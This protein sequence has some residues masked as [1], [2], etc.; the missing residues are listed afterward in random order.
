MTHLFL[1]ELVP[2]NGIFDS[3]ESFKSF[4]KTITVKETR[5]EMYF[6]YSLRFMAS[7]L[8]RLSENLAQCECKIYCNCLRNNF[9]HTF[10][11]YFKMLKNLKE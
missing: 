1:R 5:Y 3:A 10:L 11:M 9:M 2:D 8:D 6:I 7:S 4:Y